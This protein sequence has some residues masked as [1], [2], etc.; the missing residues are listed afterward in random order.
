MFYTTT[1]FTNCLALHCVYNYT[2]ED[3][4]CSAQLLIQKGIW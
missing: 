3:T 4:H 1:L 2:S